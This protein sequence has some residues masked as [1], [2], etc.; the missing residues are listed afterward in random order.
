ME[1]SPDGDTVMRRGDVRFHVPT[2]GFSIEESRI[3]GLL[4]DPYVFA[5]DS[6]GI[7][8]S[9]TLQ[10]ELPGDCREAYWQ[11]LQ[12]IPGFRPSEIVREERGAF[13]VIAYTLV[14]SLHPPFSGVRI[15]QRNAIGCVSSGGATAYL[16][17]SKVAY[18]PQ[19]DAALAAFFAQ[20]QVTLR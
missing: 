5:R 9:A 8:L 12:R 6:S 4:V 15:D 1:V 13:R 17:V 3:G 20:A 16:H 2:R 18:Q 10:S 7:V 11:R 14:E 19:D